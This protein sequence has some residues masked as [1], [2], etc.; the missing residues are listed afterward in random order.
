M[1][2][3]YHHS[4]SEKQGSKGGLSLVGTPGWRKHKM[5]MMLML[6]L[7]QSKSFYKETSFLL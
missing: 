4:A 3:L 2:S 7:C 6:M 5:H 1:V